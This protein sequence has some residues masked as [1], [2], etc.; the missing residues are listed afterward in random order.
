MD[1]SLQA[2]LEE[3]GFARLGWDAHDES[4]YIT[5]PDGCHIEL[6]GECPHGLKSPVMEMF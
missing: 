6:D 1:G 3:T 4:D 2:A 5:A